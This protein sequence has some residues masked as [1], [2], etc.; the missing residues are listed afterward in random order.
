MEQEPLRRLVQEP[1][2]PE[3]ADQGAEGRQ[4]PA[5]PSGDDE[6]EEGEGGGT[7]GGRLRRLGHRL[8]TLLPRGKLHPSGALANSRPVPRTAAALTLLLLLLLLLGGGLLAAR[9]G[10]AHRSQLAALQAQLEAQQAAL[11]AQLEA[12]HAAAAASQKQLKTQV[13]ALERSLEQLGARLGASAGQLAALEHTCGAQADA[14]SDLRA[15]LASVRD[16][17]AQLHLGAAAA[18]ALAGN[19][20]EVAAAAAAGGQRVREVAREEVA[21]ALEKFAADRTGMPDWALALVGGAVVGHSPA[22]QPAGAAQGALHSKRQGGGVIPQANRVRIV[23]GACQQRGGNGENEAAACGNGLQLCSSALLGKPGLPSSAR[24]CA[25]ISCACATSQPLP[26]PCLPAAAAVTAVPARRLPAA[27]GPLWM[28][29]HPPE[30]AHPPH[31]LVVNRAWQGY[32]KYRTVGPPAQ[33]EQLTAAASPPSCHMLALAHCLHLCS[34]HLRAHP[35]H[36][37]L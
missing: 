2:P 18:A 28:G 8:S 26:R 19:A 33:T 4:H 11:Q 15:E 3:Q 23:V 35:R 12:Q 22:S 30:A 17:I 25:A 37:R 29:G 31:R 21:A 20:S 6:E 7:P 1:P 9:Q 36:D 10:R 24:S 16:D 27:G 13:A 5:Q 14:A 32:Q 34:L